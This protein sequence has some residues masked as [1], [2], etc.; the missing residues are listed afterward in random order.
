[1]SSISLLIGCLN[2][3]LNLY[4]A[5]RGKRPRDIRC[6]VLKRVTHKANT[7]ERAAR[8]P[9]AITDLKRGNCTPSASARGMQSIHVSPLPRQLRRCRIGAFF[10]QFMVWDGVKGNNDPIRTGDNR[11]MPSV[12]WYGSPTRPQRRFRIIGEQ[13]GSP[14]LANT[15]LKITVTAIRHHTLVAVGMAS[16][17]LRADSSRRTPSS[18][19]RIATSFSSSAR[20]IVCFN[21]HTDCVASSDQADICPISYRNSGARS[22]PLGQHRVRNSG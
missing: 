7:S 8:P 6:P 10:D 2:V 1:L 18:R 21:L 5:F 22:A 12:G 19:R 20:F 4:S 14:L 11:L 16:S 17:A 9:Y 3:C 15:N 13:M